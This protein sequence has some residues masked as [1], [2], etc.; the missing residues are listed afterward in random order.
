MNNPVPRVV[1]INDLSGMGRA[2][3]TVAIPVL[4]VMG[5]Q[6]CPLPTAVLSAQTGY[7]HYSFLDFTPY[8]AAYS[9]A[10]E[11][12]SFSF[13][14]IYTG[15]LGS[16]SQISL[17]ESFCEAFPHRLLLVDPVMADNGKMYVTYTEEMCA[18]MRRLVCRADIVTPNITEACLLT[19]TPYTGESPGTEAALSL[20]RKIARFGP[21]TVVLTG[22]RTG[23]ETVANAVY[24]SGED[25][26]VFCE[27]TRAPGIYPGTGDLFSSALCGGLMRGMDARSA[28]QKAGAFV[29]HAVALTLSLGADPKDGVL[30]ERCLSDLIG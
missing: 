17:V 5:S 1:C 22:L 10:W 4:S 3:L 24:E 2:S 7:R 13:E 16:L 12:E 14:G 28:A 21:S 29:S 15:F 6:A 20:C 11:Q 23:A 30:F 26:A 8:M 18:A 25:S 27:H 19:D 9:R